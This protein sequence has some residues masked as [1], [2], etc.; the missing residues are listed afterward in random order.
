MAAVAVLGESALGV[1]ADIAAALAPPGPP[2]ADPAAWSLCRGRAGIAVFLGEAALAFGDDR[3]ADAAV[4]HLDAAVGAAA[5]QAPTTSLYSGS[6]G[7]G[8]ALT[9]LDGRLV[10]ANDAADD[11]DELV[12][13]ALPDHPAVADL[14]DGLVGLGVYLL[15]RL[16]RPGAREALD[17]LVARLAATARDGTWPAPREWLLAEEVARYPEGF[18]SLG[19]AHGLPGVVALLARLHE[20][21]VAGAGPLLQDAVGA[22]TAYARPGDDEHGRYPA[23]VPGHEP[24]RRGSRVAWCYG[25]PGVAIALLAAGRALGDAAVETEAL[26]TARAAARRPY[27]TSANVDAGLCHGSAGLVHVFA[28]LFAATGDDLFAEAAR[29]WYGVLSGQLVP[30]APFAGVQAVFDVARGHEPAAGLL[31]GAAGVGL[32]LLSATGATGS[33][34]DALLLTDGPAAVPGEAPPP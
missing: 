18:L 23:I 30:G 2:G 7:V 1:V 10:D 29:R 32:A 12:V 15:A 20:A 6:V 16:P 34:W 24:P 27:E 5:E 3:L 22:L 26:A 17:V 25:D 11:V 13:S 4:D 21:G 14:T 9:H 28:R 8:W 33:R 31:E 19:M